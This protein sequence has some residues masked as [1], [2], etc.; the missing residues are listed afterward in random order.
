MSRIV[1]RIIDGR[2]HSRIRVHDAAGLDHARGVGGHQPVN[3]IEDQ[4]GA[5]FAGPEGVLRYPQGIELPAE[6][7]GPV[8]L[9]GGQRSAD[10][11]H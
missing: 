1:R 5:V 2:L 3:V 9:P 7:C 4:A 8:D 6:G 10:L 11:P